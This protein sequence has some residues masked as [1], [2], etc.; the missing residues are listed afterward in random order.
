MLNESNILHNLKLD[1][2]NNT[3]ASSCHSLSLIHIF[4]YRLGNGQFLML[5][6][7]KNCLC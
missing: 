7:H 3:L 1:G 2:D 6:C 5:L 4:T